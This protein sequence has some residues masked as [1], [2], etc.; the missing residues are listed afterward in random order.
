MNL[1]I[2]HLGALGD[3]LLSRPALL[4]IRRSFP[5]AKISLLGYPHI[6]CLLN[7]ELRIDNIYSADGSFLISL[8]TG[9]KI[10]FWKKFDQIIFF[11]H[12]R[13][14]WEGVLKRL[15]KKVF[16]IKPFPKEGSIHVTVYQQQQLRSYGIKYNLDFIPLNL[17]NFHDISKVPQIL[18]HPGSGSPK[19]NWP[20]EK[21]LYLI[22]DF[23]NMADVGIIIGPAQWNTKTHSTGQTD[24]NMA[25]NIMVLDSLPLPKLAKSISKARVFIGN[26]SGIT[27]LAAAVGIPTIALFGPTDPRVWSPWGRDVKV[28]RHEC[29]K[30]IT[31]SEVKAAVEPFVLDNLKTPHYYVGHY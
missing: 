15:N 20:E 10:D 21:I 2:V 16:F 31:V 18:I 27:H 14:K 19:K 17:D 22:K 7:K 4:A 30:R 24:K 28:I 3:L 13:L 25:K 1:L 12:Y 11:L 23:S 8:Y 5:S 9:K 6:L 26:D 29:L